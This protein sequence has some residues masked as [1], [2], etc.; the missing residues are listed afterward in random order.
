MTRKIVVVSAGLSVPSSTRLLADQLAG[1]VEAQVSARGEGVDIEF[2]ELRDYAADLAATMTSGG[3]PTPIVARLRD[4]VTSADGLIAVT[5][6][7]TASYSGLFKMFIDVLDPKSLTGMPVLIAATAGSARHSLVL[8][9][10]MRP[11][12][13]YLRTVVVPTAVFAATED[14]GTDT[15]ALTDRITRAAS[16]LASL[17]VG[18]GG[19]AVGGFGPDRS[20][21]RSGNDVPQEVTPFE[22]LL[23][24]TG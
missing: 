18:T 9:H 14:F 17:V 12:F 2:V 22:Q 16:E 6:V 20:V 8:E 23:G 10:A 19:A 13:A 7:F 15:A 24:R 5:P 1:A 3:L 4:L 21:R 11:L